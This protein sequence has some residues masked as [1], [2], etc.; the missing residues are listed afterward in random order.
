[1]AMLFVIMASALQR[2]YLYQQEYGLTELRLYTTAFMGW[3]ALLFAWFLVT[4]LRGQ[5]ERFALGALVSGLFV[6]AVLHLINPDA[7]IV[8]TNVAHWESSGR[9]DAAYAA[10]LSPDAHPTLVEALPQLSPVDREQVRADLQLRLEH[11]RQDWRSWNWGHSRSLQALKT[12]S[13]ETR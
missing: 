6:L 1:V 3:M 10:S 9:F 2:M 13:Q 8:R 7:L 5:R 11:H 4:V 12:L